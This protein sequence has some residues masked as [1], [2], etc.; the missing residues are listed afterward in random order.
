MRT[1]GLL[2]VPFC[3]TGCFATYTSPVLRDFGADAAE[4]L[5]YGDPQAGWEAEIPPASRTIDAYRLPKTQLLLFRGTVGNPDLFLQRTELEVTRVFTTQ[6]VSILG[7]ERLDLTAQIDLALE[8]GH[9]L[10]GRN[11]FDLS[12]RPDAVEP[13]VVQRRTADQ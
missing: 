7:F 13:T 5:R 4:I 1:I 8:R 12:H 11:P 9:G 6:G 2:L 10:G 3:L